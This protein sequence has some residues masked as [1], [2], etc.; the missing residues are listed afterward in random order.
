MKL[1]LTAISLALLMGAMPSTTHARR[2]MKSN[3]ARIEPGQSRQEIEQTAAKVRPTLNQ[4]RA[5]EDEFIAFVHFGPNTFTRREWG[6]GF[7]DPAVFNP[8]SINTDQWCAAMRDAGMKKV[9]LTVKHHDGYVIWQSRYTRHGIMSSPYQNG[10]GDVLRNLSESCKKY[11]LKLGIY[12]SPADLYQIE[13]PDGLY[14]NQSPYTERTIP[15]EVEGR[16]FKNKTK[17]KFVVDD[18][19]EYF[20][21]QLFELLTEYGPIDELWFDGAHP[22]RKGNQ[23]YVYHAWRKLIRTLAPKAVIFG[24]EDI[25]WCGNESGDTRATEWNVVGYP[26][27]PDTAS[28]FHDL[29]DYDLGSTEALSKSKYMHYQPGETDTS[30]REGWFYRDERQQVR[31][32]DDIYDIYERSVG[33]NAIFLLNM[34]PNR[35]GRLGDRDVASLQEAGRMIRQTYGTNLFANAQ[36]PKKLFDGDPL[37]GIAYQDP[38][39][40]TLPQAVNINRVVIQENILKK[41]ERVAKHQVEARVNGEWKVV[42]QATNIGHK[43]IL[44]FPTVRTDALRLRVT[45]SRL[46]PYIT[47]F[48]AHYHD[49]RPPQ[50]A[51]S[52]NSKGQ[53]SI[54][55]NLGTF[56]WKTGAPSATPSA[57]DDFSIYYTTDGTQPTASTG[58]VY[59]G[60]FQ[61]EK[62]A[63]LQAVAI[64]N[65]TA[66]PVL[67]KE[68]GW[69]QAAWSPFRPASNEAGEAQRKAY[70]ANSRSAYT[71]QASLP[72]T[73]DIDLGSACQLKGV[74]LTP[75]EG[76]AAG[77]PSKGRLFTSNNGSDWTKATTYDIGNIIN[78]PTPRS[79]YFNS[80]VTARYLRLVMTAT[81]GQE[82]VT[83][84]EIEA[85]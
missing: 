15:R 14:G 64:S 35:E 74:R 11:G 45:E 7:E 43:R 25:R 54:F 48:T 77:F 29:T 28:V 13:S 44:R 72:V 36:G 63:T 18:Y 56:R 65:K 76:K 59:T 23:Q 61:L 73:I 22:K 34:P 6:T 83:L 50:L 68:L 30:I 62:A 42:A 49:A 53:V 55:P 2:D 82:P 79:V 57:E 20:L 69:A 26:F 16:P 80:P 67:N 19:N 31:T 70:D 1:S 81:A 24:R 47:T 33:G 4:W 40:I 27:N 66:G 84:A 39:E 9:L 58:Q 75:Q 46:Q 10:K 60:P 17:F 5:L 85:L 12:L 3:T 32:A 71:T 38:I 21:N 8:E 51:M 78:D 37:T 41:G 52:R